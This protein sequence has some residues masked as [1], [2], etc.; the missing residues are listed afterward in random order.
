MKQKA[1]EKKLRARIAA[2]QKQM[3]ADKSGT[4]AKANKKPGSYK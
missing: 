4:F 2:W 3:D 1:K